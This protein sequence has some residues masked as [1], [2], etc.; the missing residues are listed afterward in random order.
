MAVWSMAWRQAI[1]ASAHTHTNRAAGA[2][3]DIA[4]ANISPPCVALIGR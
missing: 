1:P 4:R 3:A 2:S